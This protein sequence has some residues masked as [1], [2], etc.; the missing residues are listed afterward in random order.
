MK[1]IAPLTVLLIVV[2]ALLGAQQAASDANNP[3]AI[4][5]GSGQKIPATLSRYFPCSGNASLP[6]GDE[7]DEIALQQIGRL[8]G[9]MYNTMSGGDSDEDSLYEAY[10]Y[11][12]DN[13][14]GNWTFTYRIYENDGSDHY[15]LAFAATEGMIPYAFGDQDGDGLPEVIG[16]WS[17]WVYVYESPA[18]GRLATQMVWQSP[19][20]TN[21]TGYTAIG[22]LDEDGLG[23]IIHTQNGWGND[24]RLVIY[25]KTGNNQFQEI[26]N[27]PVSNDNLGTKAIGDFDGD[28]LMEVAFSSGGGDVYVY[29]SNG[30]NSVQQIYRGSMNTWNAYACSYANDMDGNGR[31]EFIC[32]GSDSNRGWVTQIYEAAGNDSFVVRQEIIIWDGYF[33]VPGNCVGDFDNDGADEFVIQCAQSLRVYEWN[34]QSYAQVQNIP[35]NFGSILHGVFSYDGNYNGYDEVF[36]LGI[37][38]GGYWTNET[39]LLEDEASAQPPNVNITLQ[40]LGWAPN[41]FNYNINLTNGETTPETFDTWIMMQ[42]PNGTWHGPVLGP[43]NLT[44]PAGSSITRIRLQAVPGSAPAG[45]YW[46]VGRIGDYPS[47]VWDSSGFN[48]TITGSGDWGRGVGEWANSGEDLA[49]GTRSVAS[50]S[51]SGATPTIQVMPNPFNPTT[52]LSFELRDASRVSLQVYDISGRMVATLVEGWREAG[53]HEV[54]FDGSGLPSA[55]YICRIRSGSWSSSEKMILTK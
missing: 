42:F 36:W 52:V 16:Q 20:M 43:V 7:S 51:G 50:L 37:G 30:N 18:A 1:A 32:G 17:S 24:N 23:E 22:D 55:I 53:V 15:P 44:L 45:T 10:M 5:D 2:P 28:G 40:W 39:I 9:P 6:W 49:R 19:A 38:D 46:Y 12:K 11:I 27:Q 34:G 33:G 54:T 35:E 26:F 29:E 31:P 14:G 48:F 41:G 21:I 25:E 47:A 3:C 8:V 13:A 4:Y